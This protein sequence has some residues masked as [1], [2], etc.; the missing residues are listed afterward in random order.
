MRSAIWLLLYLMLCAAR[1]ASAEDL[2]VGKTFTYTVQPG[3][4]M[5]GI[6]ARLGVDAGYIVRSNNIAR[7]GNIQPGEQLRIDNYHIVPAGVRDGIIINIP[8]RMLYFFAGGQLRSA[9]PVGLGRS[10]WQTP[11]GAFRVVNKIENPVWHVPKNIREEMAREG[12]VV[13]TQVPPGPDN[14]LGQWW[15]GLNLPGIGIH[16][17]TTPSSVYRFQGHGCIRVNPQ[18]MELLFPQVGRNA[19]GSIIYE[20]V[21]LAVSGGRVYAEIHPDIYRKGVD[22]LDRLRQLAS[23]R[24]V[25]N[26]IDWAR[27]QELVRRQDGVAF[28]VTAAAAP[29]LVQEIRK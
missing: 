5:V 24:G 1:P 4:F 9:I 23:Q 10:D 15:I 14:P 20:P 16:A 29:D 2:I 27:A 28:D 22:M 19:R 25:V 26:R 18:D 3:D 7:P 13:R 8:Q 12:E 17:T 11:T 21:L 6:A